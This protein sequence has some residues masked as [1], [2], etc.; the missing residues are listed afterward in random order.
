MAVRWLA[1][2]CPVLSMQARNPAKLALIIGNKDQSV[3]DRLR[4]DQ[5]IQR[6]NG[7]AGTLEPR[8]NLRIRSRVVR[9]KF[10]DGNGTKEVF[11]Q[12]QRLRRR[13]ALGR[14]GPQFGF[15]NDADRNV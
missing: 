8:P 15:S 2:I 12:P 10:Q 1:L 3:N 4:R 6:T 9:G 11:Y 5:R 7:C 14:A 13:T